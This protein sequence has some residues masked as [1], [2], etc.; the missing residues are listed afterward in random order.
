MIP[1]CE[2]K[3]KSCISAVF[4]Q[5]ERSFCD[6]GEGGIRTHVP[7][8]ATAFRVQLVMTTS[9]LLLRFRPERTDLKITYI[10]YHFV[11]IR[12]TGKMAE[13]C[14]ELFGQPVGRYFPISVSL[15]LSVCHLSVIYLSSVRRQICFS[16]G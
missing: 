7:R 10:I 9:I 11:L 2:P 12:S 3:K 4:Y 1:S 5:A 13:S 15:R 8:R 16:G 14:K 6:G